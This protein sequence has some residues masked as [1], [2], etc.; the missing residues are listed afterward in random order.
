MSV[1][2]TVLR[3]G[4]FRGKDQSLN[5]VIGGVPNTSLTSFGFRVVRKAHQFYRVGNGMYGYSIEGVAKFPMEYA[6]KDGT[7]PGLSF[8]V[9]KNAR[10]DS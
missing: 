2:L 5:M 3:G 9:V 7:S 1:E 8:R 10:K 4:A 6:S